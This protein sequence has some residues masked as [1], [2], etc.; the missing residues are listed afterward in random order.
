MLHE[1][2]Q[3]RA[4]IRARR[5][6]ARDKGARKASEIPVD[7]GELVRGLVLNWKRVGHVI[8]S[9]AKAGRAQSRRDVDS[10][11]TSAR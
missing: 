4:E 7:A 2:D 9:L 1:L 10:L 3:K 8:V 5:A 6:A 11:L